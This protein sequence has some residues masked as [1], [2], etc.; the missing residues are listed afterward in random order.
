MD[1]DPRKHGRAAALGNQ[2]QLIWPPPCRLL[3]AQLIGQLEVEELFQILRLE[4]SPPSLIQSPTLSCV[5][6]QAEVRRRAQY[7]TPPSEYYSDRAKHTGSR[8]TATSDAIRRSAASWPD[9]RRRS[10][11]RADRRP[12]ATNSAAHIAGEPTNSRQ[13]APLSPGARG[14][15][16]PG[17]PGQEIP[18]NCQLANL[19]IKLRRLALMLLLAKSARTGPEK[20]RH[21]VENLLLPAID[22][23]RVN[24]VPLRQLRHRRYLAQRLQR[25]FGLECGIKL[26]A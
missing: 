12:N 24:A 7:R 26:L 18:F 8:K 13:A 15:S 1:A 10:P 2:Q 16:S 4:T 5:S 17:P 21:V 20:A 14:H 11:A 23:V 9:R 19:G 25:N 3:R 6:R 22:L